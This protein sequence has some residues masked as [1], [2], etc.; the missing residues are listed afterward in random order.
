MAD[1]AEFGTRWGALSEQSGDAQISGMR[2]ILDEVVAL[3]DE[4]RGQTIEAMVKA[5]Y[6]LDNAA[7][8]S[9]TASRL[10]AWL[11]MSSEDM[12]AAK[13]VVN[14]YDSSFERLPG[15]MAMRRATIV[16]TVARAEMTPEEVSGLFEL[17][18]SIVRQVP[19][20][21][22]SPKYVPAGSSGGASAPAKKKPAWKF[23]G[24]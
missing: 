16:Q 24:K 3:P 23:W 17:I 14:G 9:F 7:L 18:P 11:A 12:D 22:P 6:A 20:S 8:H 1:A 10:R 13:K 19:R 21:A 5:E 15:E 4:A 2:S